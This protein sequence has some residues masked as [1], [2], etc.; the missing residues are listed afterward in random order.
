MSLEHTD[1]AATANPQAHVSGVSPV[2]VRRLAEITRV[3]QQSL[4]QLGLTPQLQKAAGSIPDARSRLNYVVTKTAAAADK[5]LTSVEQA[6]LEQA[7]MVERSR[8]LASQ[9]AADPVHAVASGAVMNYVHDVEAGASSMD[10]HLTDIMMAQDFHD[11]TGQVVQRVVGLADE[12]EASLIALL[13]QVASPGAP[14]KVDAHALEGP[15]VSAGGRSDVVT[16]Q[17]E[18]DE[19]ISS[20]GF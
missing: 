13:S 14:T 8:R 15:V 19:L 4:L 7:C 9:L 10:R 17:D 20:L 12:L 3:L 2:V 1:T 16:S 5:V 6:K 18:V 11:L